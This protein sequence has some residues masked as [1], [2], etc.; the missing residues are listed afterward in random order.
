[1]TLS[2]QAKTASSPPTKAKLP[3]RQKIRAKDPKTTRATRK[4]RIKTQNQDEVNK[5]RAVEG[6]RPYKYVIYVY[7]KMR[8][9]NGRPYKKASL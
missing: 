1:M 7:Y 4:L 9:S 2:A 3:L 8:A 6:A 5:K